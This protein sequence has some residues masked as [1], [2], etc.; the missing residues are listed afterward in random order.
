MNPFKP[1]FMHLSMGSYAGDG[2]KWFSNRFHR[3]NKIVVTSKLIERKLS[4]LSE[5]GLET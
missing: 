3:K 5:N 1:H 4:Q 2:S